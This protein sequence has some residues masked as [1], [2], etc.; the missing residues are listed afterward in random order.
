M[1]QH[2]CNIVLLFPTLPHESRQVRQQMVEKYGEEAAM[3]SG[4]RVYTTVDSRLQAAATKAL[5]TALMDYDRR[6]GYRGPERHIELP[7]DATVGHWQRAVQGIPAL[8]GLQPAVVTRVEE[9]AVEAEED[10]ALGNPLRLRRALDAGVVVVM[11]HCASLGTDE[12]LDAPGRPRVPSFSLFL[13][14]MDDPRYAGLL[15]GEISAMTQFNRI[16]EPLTT[17]LR[18]TDLH[19]RLVNGSDYPVSAANFV[20]WTRTLKNEG[21]LTGEER[22][23]LNEIYRRNPLLYDFALKRT[24]RHPETG[25]RFPPTVFMAHPDIPLEVER[26]SRGP[27][28]NPIWLL[29]I[30][31]IVPPVA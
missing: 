20:I 30:I 8:G 19:P 13:R 9:Q 21:F 24:L 11:A 23:H 17:M 15:Y 5:R 16:G 31:W 1:Q 29:V 2:Q 12:D 22:G 10:Q 27:V 26:A 6:H 28:V 3:T 4:Y 18:R 14:L 7:P 25:A